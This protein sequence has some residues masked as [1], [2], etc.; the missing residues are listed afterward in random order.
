M[1]LEKNDK[2]K[3]KMKNEGK[4]NNSFQICHSLSTAWHELG[5]GLKKKNINKLGLSWAKLSYQ[6]GFGS[7][8]IK[9]CCIIS[10]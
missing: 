8:L 1:K 5:E 2:K 3:I 7:T 10:K 6:M 4:N 9:T